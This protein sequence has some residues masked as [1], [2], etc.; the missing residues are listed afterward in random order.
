MRA[1]FAYD[2]DVANVKIFNTDLQY[3]H[4]VRQ[5]DHFLFV[6]WQLNILTYHREKY[7]KYSHNS[8][9][10]TFCAVSSPAWRDMNTYLKVLGW[11]RIMINYSA[12]A[13]RTNGM[14]GIRRRLT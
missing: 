10:N 2:D 6:R 7:V 14:Y 3:T 13:S 4:R 12:S 5:T 1:H 8:L 9:S 11:H